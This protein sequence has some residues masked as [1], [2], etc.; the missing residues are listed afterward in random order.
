MS[1]CHFL[2]KKRKQ[3]FI[4]LINQ[5]SG[6]SIRTISCTTSG[7]VITDQRRSGLTWI[8]MHTHFLC[9]ITTHKWNIVPLQQTVG[10]KGQLGLS[11]AAAEAT[12]VRTGRSEKVSFPKAEWLPGCCSHIRLSY[13]NF[14]TFLQLINCSWVS[15]CVLTEYL[16]G[17]C[18]SESQK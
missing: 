3:S 11:H 8:Q 18:S 12:S 17:M 4:W 14:C 7:Q 13:S 15:L 5:I 6:S 10:L 16:I 1:H 2:K 9:F